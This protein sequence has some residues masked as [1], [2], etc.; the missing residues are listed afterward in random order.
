MEGSRCSGACFMGTEVNPSIIMPTLPL[1]RKTAPALPLICPHLFRLEGFCIGPGLSDFQA[2][3]LRINTPSLNAL[4]VD[5]ITIKVQ[6]KS[7]L[8]L[9]RKVAQITFWLESYMA[10]IALLAKLRSLH[11][12][13]L[14]PSI[15][16]L[17][18]KRQKKTAIKSD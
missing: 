1:Y 5:S 15:R 9:S 14:H 10:S 7:H 4:Q 3:L 13:Q 18:C 12:Y 17:S 2:F 11:P 8:A 6:I 16:C